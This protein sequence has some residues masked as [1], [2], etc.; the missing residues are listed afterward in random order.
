MIAPAPEYARDVRVAIVGTGFSGLAVAVR[1]KQAG[2]DDFVLLERGRDIGGTWRDNTY[3]GAACDVPSH[4]YSFSFAPNPGWSRSFS[5]QHEILDYLRG[6]A[7]D[8]A[9]L[10]H[11]RFAHE[12]RQARWDARAARWVITTTRGVYTARVL[13]AAMGALSDPKLPDVPGIETFAGTIFHSATWNHEHDLAGERVAVIGTG[14]SAIQFVPRIQPTVGR[15]HVFQRTPPWILPR[16]DRAFTRF[17][18]WLCRRVPVFQRLARLGIYCSREMSVA[19]FTTRPGLLKVMAVLARRHLRKQVADPALRAKLT[20]GYAIGCKR[21]LIANDYYPALTHPNV[22][23]VTE[24]IAEVRPHAIVTTDGVERPIDTL[25]CG[26]GFHVTDMPFASRVLD[27]AG[28]SLA[29]QWAAAG[30]SAYRGTTV[31]GFPN[32]FLM[33]GPNTGLGHNSMVLMIEAQAGYVADALAT[34][35]ADG[36]D[37]IDVRPEI[38]ERYNDRIQARMTRTVWTTGGCASW[39][40]DH[41]GRNTTLWPASTWIF[42]RTMRRFDVAAYT[43]ASLAPLARGDDATASAAA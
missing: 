38:Q 11:C 30:M 20:P 9:I 36:V 22:E 13:V 42:R 28:R 35:R 26:T 41:R 31:S 7:R 1:L 15:L 24:R 5:P 8:F 33:V 25:I 3:P 21:I 12:V 4:L 6:V 27:G 23:V 19:G 29:E 10:P 43:T 2:I 18:Q 40:L 16:A 37:V 32:L 39:Y 17:E 14:A 34:M